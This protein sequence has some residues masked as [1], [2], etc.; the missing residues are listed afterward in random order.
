[1][2][3]NERF[4]RYVGI[5]T[6]SERNT[7]EVPSAM[8]EFDLANVLS[9]EMEEIGLTGV[10]VDNYGI[11]YGKL[12]ATPGREG[13]TPIGLLA[14]MDTFPG[15]SGKDVRPQ[16]IEKYD[17]K[18][19]KLGNSG[20]V[21]SCSEYPHL[22]ALAGQTLITTDG[23]TLL[24]ADDKAGIAEIMTALD[25]I[26]REKIPHG[27]VSVAFLPDEEIG[28][29]TDYFDI[30]KF[31]AR[32]AYTVDGW[33]PG[34]ITYENFNAATIRIDIRGRETH[35][36]R[37]KGCLLNA[38]LVAIEINS[39][40]PAHEIPAMTEGREGF[41]HLRT[42]SGT[43][44]EA[45]LE[46]AVRDHDDTRYRERIS[47]LT[48]I[49]EEMNRKY[50]ENT[51]SWDLSEEYRNMKSC[52]EPCRHL[53]DHAVEATRAAGLTPIIAPA[54]GGTD[55]ARLSFRGLPCPNLGIGGYAYH[56]PMEHITAEAM[57]QV[58]RILIG[59]IRSYAD[60]TV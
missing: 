17:G 22:K 60:E 51:V 56:G 14:H 36:G 27:P 58:T 42:S 13:N 1:M 50:G 5:W 52:I 55:G 3:V 31:G 57:D 54:R 24:G 19:V 44:A 37:G 59:I 30:K 25:R 28:G 40:L 53:V 46:Y 49:C 11:V 47:F 2:M 16:I 45:H 8:R 48:D 6:S 38:Q 9:F 7:N 26:Q 35:T 20:L 29:G 12:P 32:Y 41:Y 34:E 15:C 39:R 43:V 21:L 23:T 10:D 4:L 33:N 18:D